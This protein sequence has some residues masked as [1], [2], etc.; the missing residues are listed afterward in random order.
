MAES[1]KVGFFGKLSG[2][3]DFV[4]R[5]L[6]AAF[7]GAW[8]GHFEAALDTARGMLG[9]AWHATWQ[10]APVWRFAL[11]PGVC[12]ADAWVGVT[13]PALDRVGRA[14][15]MVLACAVADAA[16]LARLVAGGGGWFDALER[17]C[18]DAHVHAG[19]TVASFEAAVNALSTPLDWL[20]GVPAAPDAPVDWAQAAAWRMP[21]RPAGEDRRLA[22][23]WSACRDIA[24]GCLWWTRGGGRVP[25]TIL[26]TRGLP[27]PEAYAAFLDASQGGAHW[28]SQGHF[29]M[30]WHDAASVSSPGTATSDVIDGVLADLL[31]PAGPVSDVASP[32]PEPMHGDAAQAESG[33]LAAPAAATCHAEGRITSVVADNG[34]GDPRRRAAAQMAEV[35]ADPVACAD[36][37]RL[38]ERLLALHAPLQQRREDLIDPVAEDGAAIVARRE[39]GCVRLLRI[40]AAVAWH[41]RRG[42]LRPLFAETAAP[43]PDQATTARPGD[44]A[45]VLADAGPGPAAGLGAATGPRCEEIT[46]LVEPADRL[47]LLA[48][49]P[50]ASLAAQTVAAALATA[51]GDACRHIAAA[52]GLDADRTR[53]PLAV[54]EVEA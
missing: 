11:A 36:M 7:V 32:V 26:L 31:A 47:L 16:V 22:A 33:G 43:A 30:T 54:I 10:T 3:G 25:P 50:L 5:R 1:G 13:G 9:D 49:D 8:D 2:T 12:G 40:G 20:D 27:P 38:R 19:A 48:T 51:D 4:Q 15:P 41:W 17:V 37:C 6:P 45:G 52:A 28:R 23:Q 35:L 34:P 14:F 44:L 39:N 53:W 18:R 46:C 24:E 42:R 21:W 29:E